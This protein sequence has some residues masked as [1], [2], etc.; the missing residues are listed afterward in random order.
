MSTGELVILGIAGSLRAGSYNRA[1]LR[2]A[3]GLL[4]PGV[5]METADISAIPLYNDD[6][7]VAHMPEPVEALKRRI[8][9]ADAVLIATPEYNYSI[10]GVLKN[11]LDWLSKTEHQP[12]NRKPAA[13]MGASQGA[14]GTARC[15]YHLRQVL[16]CLNA[17]T[18]NRPEV[19]VTFAQKKFGAHGN[20]ADAET[21]EQIGK[22]VHA[23]VDWTKLLA[24]GMAP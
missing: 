13:I 17:L 5:T 8:D 4:P 19:I 14:R 16:V 15:Q 24:K 20:L 23:L 10:P 9:A 1:L 6:A 3:G 22:L 2:V 12:F 21:R 18:V 11:V 7:R